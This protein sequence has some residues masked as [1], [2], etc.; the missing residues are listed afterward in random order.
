MVSRNIKCPNCGVYNK[1]RDY[2]S[3]CGTVLSYQKRRELAY[4][5]EQ[6][7]RLKRQ[8]IEK[9]NNPSFFEKYENHRFWIVRAV[10]KV[11]KSIY[12]AIMAIGM[13]IAWLIATV[14]A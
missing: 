9:E 13:F 12:M 3:E 7:D 1:N 5:K 2:C 8:R 6:E 10:V 4:K 14:A 11:F